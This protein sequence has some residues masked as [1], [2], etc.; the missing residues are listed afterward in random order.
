MSE[1]SSTGDPADQRVRVQGEPVDDYPE[2]APEAARG[3]VRRITVV[4]EDVLHRVNADVPAGML[5]TPELSALIDDMFLTMYVAEGVG[6][7]GNQ[8]G[9]D[10]RLFVYD[11]PDDDGVRHVGHVINP[12][13]AE[14]DAEAVPLVVENEGCL[15]V[16][17]PHAELP[18]AEYAKVTGVD[19]DGAPV[20]VEGTGYFA[21][22]LQH[23]TDHT[24]G[25]LY[26]DRLA[27]RPRKKVLKQMKEMANDV[28]AR[29]EA[30]AA[31]LAGAEA[32]AE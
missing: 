31:E 25:R 1:Q 26:I 29:R 17:G 15:S 23:E 14:R 28:F 22:C 2:M 3:R 12:V 13:L 8:V 30:N 32:E 9:E 27:A 6:L 7:A 19:K 20:E 21:R 11:C 18:R 16:P 10:L 24:Y 4:G 5:G